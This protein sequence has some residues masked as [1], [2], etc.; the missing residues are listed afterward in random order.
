MTPEDRRKYEQ[1][2]AI[3]EAGDENED[4]FEYTDITINEILD[5]SA[6]LEIS[7]AGGEY[8]ELRDALVY[9]LSR[10]FVEQ[11]LRTST[12]TRTICITGTIIVLITEHAA[13]GQESRRRPLTCRSTS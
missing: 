7:H 5:G 12:N 11:F 13:I 3:P 8:E 2:R 1:L 9:T 10:R 6:P 4:N